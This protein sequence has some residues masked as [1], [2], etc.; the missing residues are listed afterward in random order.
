[1]IFPHYIGEQ[2]LVTHHPNH[3]W[4]FLS[5]QRNNEFTLLKC[6]DSKNDVARCELARRH[7]FPCL[8]GS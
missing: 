3:M 5:G 4:Y 7:L 1:L 2:Y 6:W 8:V